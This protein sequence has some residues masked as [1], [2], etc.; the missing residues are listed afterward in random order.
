MLEKKTGMSY[1]INRF[2]NLVLSI[3]TK[4]NKEEYNQSIIGGTQKGVRRLANHWCQLWRSPHAS[5]H[6]STF[7]YQVT[8]NRE[9]WL[10]SAMKFVGTPL[11]FSTPGYPFQK[12]PDKQ[13]HLLGNVPHAH[14][15]GVDVGRLCW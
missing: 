6:A 5:I 4:E 15:A 3:K 9:H 10:A 12:Q 13:D 7:P 14:I 8:P 1:K 2:S 11:A